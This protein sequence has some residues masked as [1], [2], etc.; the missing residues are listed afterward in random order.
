M[1]LP[2]KV[3]KWED[4]ISPCQYYRSPRLPPACWKLAGGDAASYAEVG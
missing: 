4:G 3:R 1:L 2:P